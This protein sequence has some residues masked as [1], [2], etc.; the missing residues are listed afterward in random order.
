[1]NIVFAGV[2]TIK[3]L[4]VVLHSVSFQQSSRFRFRYVS[5]PAA[6]LNVPDQNQPGR[7]DIQHRK[8]GNRFN[9][10]N[11]EVTIAV[12]TL[13]YFRF[14]YA[15]RKINPNCAAAAGLAYCRFGCGRVSCGRLRLFTV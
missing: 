1:M 8:T 14:D 2:L 4:A 10:F 11:S 9:S 7:A 13:I 6:N 5:K 15:V 12:L 3:L